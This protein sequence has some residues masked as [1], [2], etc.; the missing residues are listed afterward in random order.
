MT[1]E[2]YM[3]KSHTIKTTLMII[4]CFI[5][6]TFSKEPEDGIILT[7]ACHYKVIITTVS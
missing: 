6:F 1:P 3:R 5:D 7:E 2:Y 4:L